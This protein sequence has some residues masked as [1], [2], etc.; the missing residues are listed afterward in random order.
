MCCVYDTLHKH[1]K[2]HYALGYFKLCNDREL[3]KQKV[4]KAINHICFYGF[5]PDSYKLGG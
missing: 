1:C 2:I 5:I 3:K 4:Y